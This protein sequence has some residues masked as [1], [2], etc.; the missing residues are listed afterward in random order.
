M[1]KVQSLQ[2]NYQPTLRQG[3][4]KFAQ[5]PSFGNAPGEL[6][7]IQKNMI[8][9]T[10]LKDHLGVLGKF[11]NKLSMTTGELQNLII[12]NLGTAFVAPFFIANNPLSDEDPKSK[13]YSAWRQPISALI[14]VP[15]SMGTNMA[16]NRWFDNAAANSVFKK[17]DMGAAPSDEYL[18]RTYRKINKALEGKNITNANISELKLDLKSESILRGIGVD[19]FKQIQNKD[20]TNFIEKAKKITIA[21]SAQSL[22]DV[23]GGL[24]DMTFKDFLVQKLGFL[25]SDY[26]K[27]QSNSRLNVDD[28]NLKLKNIKAMTFL[29]EIGMSDI[30]ENKLR[31]FINN[32]IYR[33]DEKLMNECTELAKGDKKLAANMLKML[34]GIAENTDV[35]PENLEKIERMFSERIPNKGLDDVGRKTVSKICESF[36]S[37]ETLNTEKIPLETLFKVLGIDTKFEQHQI[38]DVKMDKFLLAIDQ[39]IQPNAS[40]IATISQG[41][42]I[43]KTAQKLSGTKFNQEQVNIL[44]GYAKNIVA[45]GAK[46]AGSAL[47]NYGKV[48]GIIVSALVIPL[49][50]TLLNWAHPRIMEKFFPSLLSKS[51]SKG[52]K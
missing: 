19:E 16:V 7:D 1:S 20:M 22:V 28:V 41:N 49:Q 52:G 14:A 42:D 23:S 34:N 35:R 39:M 44:L 30:G 48:Q 29:K 40:Q 47:K 51:D 10:L 18:K 38:L 36:I 43:L 17:F 6:S 25:T 11:F 12:Q 21:K 8:K 31:G 4:T 27:D 32:N 15:I 33:N 13:Q 24:K 50:C 37:Q 46:K 9:D 26:Y 5:A 3:Q 2:P 45:N